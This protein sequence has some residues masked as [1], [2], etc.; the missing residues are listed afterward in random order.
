[1]AFRINHNIASMNAYRNLARNDM[2]LSKS[3][4]A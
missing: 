2:G 1:M 3:L 4:R